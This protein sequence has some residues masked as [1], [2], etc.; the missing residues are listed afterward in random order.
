MLP[1]TGQGAAQAL[2]DAIALGLALANTAGIPEALRR[3]E[4]VRSARTKRLVMRGRRAAWA[5]TTDS[6]VLAGV[7]EALI[8]VVPARRMA[9]MFML[10]GEADPHRELR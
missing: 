4:Q 9:R 8:R 7:R 3:Y 6:G 1:H 2:E 5:T 10:A